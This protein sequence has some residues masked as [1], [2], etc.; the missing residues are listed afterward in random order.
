MGDSGHVVEHGFAHPFG[1]GAIEAIARGWNVDGAHGC[2]YPI[3]GESDR[4]AQPQAAPRVGYAPGPA[5]LAN[6]P[7]WADRGR[8]H[9]AE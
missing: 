5:P 3:D 9:V 7:R 6:P 1:D 8:A 4:V 2:S